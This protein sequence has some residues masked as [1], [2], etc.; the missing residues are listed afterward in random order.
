[1]SDDDN[2]EFV[3]EVKR[4]NPISEVVGENAELVQRGDK[5]W[6]K[7]PFRDEKNPSFCVYADGERGWYDFGEQVGGDV[8]SYVEKRDGIK[9]EEALEKLAIRAGIPHNGGDRVS[10][11]PRVKELAES[12]IPRLR[13]Q[14]LLTTAAHFYHGNLTPEIREGIRNQYGFDDDCIDRF[15]IGWATGNGLLG[16]LLSCKDM[17]KEKA[18]ET[19]LFL[20]FKDGRFVE[21]F[22]NR[23]IFPYWNKNYVA[24]FIGRR[25]EG[26]TSD[27]EYEKAKYK[28]LLTHSDDNDY[29]SKYVANDVFFGEDSVVGHVDRLIITEGVTDAISALHA[30]FPCISPV[31]V[32]FR[33]KD[34]PKLLEFGSR[35]KEIFIINDEEEGQVNQQTGRVTYPGLE[36]ALK[37]AKAFFDAGSDARILRLPREE[38]QTKVDLN[39]FIKDKGKDALICEMKSASPYPQFLIEDIPTDIPTKDINERIVA[40]AGILAKCG[41]LDQ[42]TY[43]TKIVNKFK[44]NGITKASILKTIRI[45]SR[46]SIPPPASGGTGHEG[47]EISWNIVGQIYEDDKTSTYYVKKPDCHDIVSSFVIVPRE[48]ITTEIGDAIKGHVYAENGDVVIQDVQFPPNC[49]KCKREFT[50]YANRV[51]PHMRWMGSDDNVQGLLR[52]V[53]AVKVPRYKGTTMLG[54]Y[55]DKDGPRWVTP[56]AIIGPDGPIENSDLRYVS[57]GNAL[58]KRVNYEFPPEN[59]VKRIAEYVMPRVMTMNTPDVTMPLIGWFM[60]AMVAPVV[61]ETIGSFPLLWVFG[62]AGSGKTA[63]IRDVMWPLSGVSIRREPFSVTDTEFVKLKTYSS[64]T[65]IPIPA[66]EYRP[67][68][69]KRDRVDGYHRI[70]RRIYGGESE[71]RGRSDQLENEYL[72]IAPSCTMGESIPDDTALKERMICVTPDKT[73]ITPERQQIFSEVENS[74]IGRLAGPLVKFMLTRNVVE[75]L[76][77]SKTVTDSILKTIDIKEVPPR[78]KD[79]FISMTL[80]IHLWNEFANSLRIVLPAVDIIHAYKSIISNVLGRDTSYVKDDVDR[81]MEDLNSYHNMGVLQEGIHYRGFTEPD[82]RDVICIDLK[83]CLFLYNSQKRVSGE[84]NGTNGIE[85]IKK[86]IKEK[87]KRGS[88]FVSSE[89]RIDFNGKKIR[90]VTFD[91]KKIPEDLDI[92]EWKVDQRSGHGRHYSSPDQD[93]FSSVS[94][95]YLPDTGK[96]N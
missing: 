76:K 73:S 16:H 79:N 2:R 71:R 41:P 50:S 84:E 48:K 36:G 90:A 12:S 85:S 61:H 10:L 57:T 56:H 29:V 21:F 45:E 28:K 6:C 59:E 7:S 5:L 43:I 75:D 15:N 55:M 54:Y 74:E 46:N 65:S 39:S 93:S 38:G 58:E 69:M 14:R 62:T 96:Q 63:T 13:V 95:Q 72:L 11:D 17:T 42:D 47:E 92:S 32:R 52:M 44:K 51:S 35:A 81:F 8:I 70:M 89:H 88:Y 91:P 27:T 23:I 60:A 33:G 4:K 82:G 18:Y 25:V 86:I 83:T 78:C 40:I 80:G 87:V 24:Y 3:E 20:R 31:T 67:R 30:G 34:I 53:S 49:W 9:F 64:T 37:T 1:M 66:D 26:I 68:D 94:Q 19:G 77:Y 22:N